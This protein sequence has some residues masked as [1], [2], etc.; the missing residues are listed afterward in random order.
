MSG[1]TAPSEAAAATVVL[2]VELVEEPSSMS[3]IEEQPVTAT[4]AKAMLNALK[5]F[6]D[7]VAAYPIETL[8]TAP[9]IAQK[10]RQKPAGSGPRR[11]LIEAGN[12]AEV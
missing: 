11:H 2:D 10:S 6:P 12:P 3:D 9:P 8:E 7:A 1:D 4:S 5:A